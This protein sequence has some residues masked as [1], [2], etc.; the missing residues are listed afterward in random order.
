MESEKSKIDRYVIEAVRKER[1]AQRISQEMLAYGIGK[2]RGFIGQVENPAQ[3][4]RYNLQHLNEIAN[5]LGVSPRQFLPEN[6]L[7]DEE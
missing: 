7:Q 4:A 3:R 2:S 6:S 1:M 5:F